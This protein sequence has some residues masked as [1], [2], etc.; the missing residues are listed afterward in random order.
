M[1]EDCKVV[2]L[3]EKD[4]AE[5]VD[6]IKQR[7]CIEEKPEKCKYIKYANEYINFDEYYNTRNIRIRKINYS[8]EWIS[9]IKGDKEMAGIV[10]FSVEY[11]SPVL[12]INLIHMK[13]KEMGVFSNYFN[14]VVDILKKNVVFYVSKLRASL[15]EEDNRNDIWKDLFIKLGFKVEARRKHGEE[16]EKNCVDYVYY[17]N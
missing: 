1:K 13:E 10:A 2:L 11:G 16:F 3:E 17:L 9:F 4:T 14:N 8:E 15:I 7:V 12:R 5:I 6:Y